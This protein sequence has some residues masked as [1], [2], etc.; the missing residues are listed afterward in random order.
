MA[1]TYWLTIL[2]DTSKLK[3]AIQAA[4]RGHKITADFGV[5][6]AQ[7]RK[8]GEFAG[9]AAEQGASKSKPKI[10][11]EADRPASRKA[12]ED[13]AE[14]AAK[15]I[16]SKRPK[17][18]PDADLPGSRKAGQDAGDSAVSGIGASLKKLGPLLGGLSVLGGL[19]S[20]LSEGMAFTE[21]LNV[22]QGVTSA[23]ARRLRRFPT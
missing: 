19:K 23:T 16:R 17:V 22:M 8:A 5:D 18:K 4:M 1:G 12:G 3:P 13:A 6:E 20:S 7:A 11:P 2:P 10:K 15:P 14:E 21:S 9:K